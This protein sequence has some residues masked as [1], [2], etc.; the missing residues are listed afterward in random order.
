MTF[1]NGNGIGLC[2]EQR[3][4]SNRRTLSLESMR[5]K[6]ET[7]AITFV[8]LNA[9]GLKTKRKDKIFMVSCYTNYEE[10]QNLSFLV[11]CYIF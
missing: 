2:L 7:I 1:G 6:V 5:V 9:E 4:F 11:L 3:L 10:F 8:Q